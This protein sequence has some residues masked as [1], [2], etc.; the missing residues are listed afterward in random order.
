MAELTNTKVITGP[1]TRFSYLNVFEPKA[2]ADGATP[3]YSVSLII[4]KS[5][6]K[7]VEAVR[8]AIKAAYEKDASKIKGSN[9]KSMPV[10]SQIKTPLRDGDTERPDDDAYKGSYFINANST[11]KPG[12]V[13][14]ACND[15]I[16]RSEMYS[17]CY[18]RASITFFGYN[19]NGNRGIG[20]NLNNLQ[21]LKD[22]EPLGGRA[23]A[24]SDFATS[25]EEDI[26]FLN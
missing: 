17:G 26:D 24:A 18:G 23:T 15:I 14:A 20:A 13:D 2:M 25:E 7:T 11:M 16:D 12:V 8:A 19:V 21:K 1:N 10:L 22:G 6:K 9:G 4:S 5:D 3:K